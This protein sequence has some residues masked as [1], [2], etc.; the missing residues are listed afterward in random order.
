MYNTPTRRKYYPVVLSDLQVRTGMPAPVPPMDEIPQEFTERTNRYNKLVCRWFA[1]GLDAR[2]LM[3][4]QGIDRKAAIY[5]L[6]CLMN[7]FE[8][9]HEHKIAAIAYLMSEWF[10]LPKE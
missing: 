5:H 1:S 4:K 6:T 7:S 8:L 10:T 9:R 3:V 2:S